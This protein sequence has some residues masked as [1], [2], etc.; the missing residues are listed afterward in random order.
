MS[1]DEGNALDVGDSDNDGND[2][3]A[4]DVKV[5]EVCFFRQSD[6]Q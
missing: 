3:N 2:G 5:Y 6:H 1:F 4:P